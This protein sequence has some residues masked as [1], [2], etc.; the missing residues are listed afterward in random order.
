VKKERD[1]IGDVISSWNAAN[2]EMYD[3]YLVPVSWE[4]DVPPDARKKPQEAINPIIDGADVIVAVFNTR[5]GSPTGKAESG[6]V[7]EITRFVDADKP[8]ILYF[9]DQKT[10]PRSA[11]LRQ[12]ELLQQFRRACEPNS[13]YATYASINDLKSQFDRH[14]SQHVTEL[15]KVSNSVASDGPELKLLWGNNKDGALTAELGSGIVDEDAIW[16][17]LKSKEPRLEIGVQCLG[18]EPRRSLRILRMDVSL[19]FRTPLSREQRY[20][21]RNWRAG[22]ACCSRGAEVHACHQPAGRSRRAVLPE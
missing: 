18:K 15:L 17:Y 12:W 7:E 2:S 6:T 10:M 21:L 14:L 4:L 1:A 13:Y 22:K 16:E 5:L 19:R 3:V 9:S 20:G 11:D 8:V